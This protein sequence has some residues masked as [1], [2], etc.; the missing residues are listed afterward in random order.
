MAQPVSQG[1]VKARNPVVVVVTVLAVVLALGVVAIVLD[2]IFDPITQAMIKM[3]F[4][5]LA[6]CGSFGGQ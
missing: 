2:V 6:G 3:T 5:M 4:C 1:V